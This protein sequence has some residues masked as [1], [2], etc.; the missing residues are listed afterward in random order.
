MP[1]VRV[2]NYLFGMEGFKADDVF[3]NYNHT[4]VYYFFAFLLYFD[5]FSKHTTSM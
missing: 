1:I 4:L 2:L 5:T 3:G